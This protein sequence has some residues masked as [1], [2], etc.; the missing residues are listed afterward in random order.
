MNDTLTARYAQLVGSPVVLDLRPPAEGP[1]E[2]ILKALSTWT[3][4]LGVQGGG[5]WVYPYTE[6]DDVRR[7][8]S[9]APRYTLLEAR[10]LINQAECAEDGHDYDYV[11]SRVDG[12]LVGVTC[13]RCD[14]RWSIE[15]E[16]LGPPAGYVVVDIA[17]VNDGTR[18][19][20]PAA[21]TDL[22]RAKADLKWWT[23][24]RWSREEPTDLRVA[25]VTLLPGSP[26]PAKEAG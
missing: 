1:T 23:S 21:Q 10:A 5:E 16:P 20:S 3:F 11:T 6:V 19:V 22:E 12:D 13:G 24:Q 14:R 9:H 17:T 8:G 7:A 2:G 25:R 26:A 4:V 15:R 18:W